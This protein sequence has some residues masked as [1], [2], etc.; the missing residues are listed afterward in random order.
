MDDPNEQRIV[1]E[2]HRL[3]Y[4]QPH[5]TWSSTR[6]MGSPICKN[7]FDLWIYQEI[8]HEVRPDIIVECGTYAGG[9]A[10]YF[11]SLCD[12]FGKGHVV[13]VDAVP[14]DHRPVHPRIT[15][16]TGSSISPEV[17]AAVQSRIARG[18]KVLVTLDSCHAASHVYEEM[19]L[20]GQL[21]TSGSY[22]IVEDGNVNGHPVAPEH[23]PGPAEAIAEFMA[24]SL[25]GS[26]F[27]V[28]RSR[29][30]FFMTFNPSGY[31]R[32]T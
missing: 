3:Y 30:K 32:K 26:E 15:Y 17:T 25:L 27:V 2:F 24:R 31:L 22:L 18:N 6:W 23:G 4:S 20:Y 19:Q 16:L 5:R 9:S 8:L 1:D 14:L 21:V 13:T 12:L 28:D 7:P 11:A 29:E 10:L